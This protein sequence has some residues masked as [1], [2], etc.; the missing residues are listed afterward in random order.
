MDAHAQPPPRSFALGLERLGLVGLA[1]PAI[2]ILLV[3]LLS[4]GAGFGKLKVD[5]SL[6]ELFGWSRSPKRLFG[7]AYR[8]Q[9]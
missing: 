8:D 4:I 7:R 1:R 5:D 6:S 2:M 9:Q 3:I